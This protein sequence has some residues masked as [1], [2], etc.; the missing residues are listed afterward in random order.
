MSMVMQV[1]HKVQPH[2]KNPVGNAIKLKHLDRTHYR[3]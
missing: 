3:G 2:D 1:S